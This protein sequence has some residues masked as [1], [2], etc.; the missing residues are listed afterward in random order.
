MRSL[1]GRRGFTLIELL[2]VIMI[3]GVLVGLMLPAVQAAREAARRAQC[4]NNLKQI[5]LASLNYETIWAALPAGITYMP[6]PRTRN[7]SSTHGVFVSLLPFLENEALFDSVNFKC[8]IWTKPNLTVSAIGLN[9]LWC[10]SDSGV[11]QVR[12]FDPGASF[13]DPLPPGVFRMQYTSYSGNAGTWF[14]TVSG[15]TPS[16]LLRL[17]QMNGLFFPRSATRMAGVLDGAS[18]TLAFGEHAHSILQGDDAI[19]WH[20]W[21]SGNYGD[22]LFN[23]MYPI[24]PQ[25]RTGNA[26][27]TDPYD[28]TTADIEACSSR[29]PGGA[30]FA[31]LD[32]SVRFLKDTIDTWPFDPATQMPVGLI[33]HPIPAAGDGL[34]ALTHAGRMHVYQI[35]STIAGR[36]VVSDD[37]F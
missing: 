37:S 23:T 3:I 28:G 25:S 4:T 19:S 9:T 36:D 14:Q 35:L 27:D 13:L 21:D 18:H 29:H 26:H 15:L 33:Q 22:T 17:S 32:G 11:D 31:F 1:S 6:V 30:N 20:W 2:V 7:V 5:A 10:P 12:Q 16:G 34:Y 24:N 8:C